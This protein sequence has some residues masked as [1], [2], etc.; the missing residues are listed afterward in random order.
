MDV[1]HPGA[2]IRTRDAIEQS[3]VVVIGTLLEAGT[4][5]PG[6]PGAHRIDNAKFR[7]DEILTPTSKEPIASNTMAV[8]YLRQ[9]MPAAAAEAPL[10]T[11]M[12]YVL[13]CTLKPGRQLHALKLVPHSTEAVRIVANAFETGA[14]HSAAAIRLA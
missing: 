14:Q 7:V 6:P 12:R 3:A 4:A 9:V 1:K 2:G 13:F 8:S 11:G 5:S 10:Q